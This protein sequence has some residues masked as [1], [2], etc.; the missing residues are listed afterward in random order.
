MDSDG[1]DK[2]IGGIAMK[3]IARVAPFFFFPTTWGYVGLVYGLASTL[4]TVLKSINSIVGKNDELSS[5]FTL[6]E[7]WFRRFTPTNS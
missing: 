2:S 1:I 7:N 5:T 6:A 3:T 4:P